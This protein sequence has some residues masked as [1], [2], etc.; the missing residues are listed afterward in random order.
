MFLAAPRRTGKST[1]LRRELIPHLIEVG[2][3]P[4][5]VDLWS[6]RDA[7]PG[8]LIADAIAS[9]LDD[10]YSK[11]EKITNSILPKSISVGGVTVDL[12]AGTSKRIGT[13]KDALVAIG[14]KAQK[15]VALII[16]E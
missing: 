11:A 13:L 8:L 9:E 16:D 1:F 10:L 7:D 5:Y 2:S 3:F 4:I 15:D 12:E 14:E 6:D